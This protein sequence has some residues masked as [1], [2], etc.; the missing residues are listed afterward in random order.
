MPDP[1]EKC[2]A[3]CQKLLLDGGMGVLA[4]DLYASVMN[5]TAGIRPIDRHAGTFY[6]R[7]VG[8]LLGPLVTAIR[9]AGPLS[10][11]QE[12]RLAAQVDKQC[13]RAD[14]FVAWAAADDARRVE[15][16]S[17]WTNKILEWVKEDQT[18]YIAFIAEVNN[19]GK[20][21]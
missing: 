7:I 5:E 12:Q 19:A 11:D 8:D 9:D 1:G 21:G 4:A 13:Y 18:F 6:S 16:A 10:P 2:D 17:F 14:G 20:S 15:L 3:A